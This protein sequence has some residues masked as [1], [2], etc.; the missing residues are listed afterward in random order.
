MS[1]KYLVRRDTSAWVLQVWAAFA[2][3]VALCVGGI[4]HLPAEGLNRAF[5]ALGYLFCLSS[6]FAVAKT[7]RDNRD[8]RV[9]TQQWVFQVWAA[10]IIAVGVTAWGLLRMD[11]NGW[12]KAYLLATWLFLIAATFTLAKTVRDNHEAA[13]LEGEATVGTLAVRDNASA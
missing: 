9:D 2:I 8:E 11:A 6:A 5:I 7:V 1:Q 12:E 3:A 10:F 4:W 13:V